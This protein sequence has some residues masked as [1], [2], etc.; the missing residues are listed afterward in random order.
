MA[1]QLGEKFTGRFTPQ[2]TR[3]RASGGRQDALALAVAKVC[4]SDR[5]CLHE[6]QGLTS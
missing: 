1:D 2:L 4:L 5:P 6:R 3:H